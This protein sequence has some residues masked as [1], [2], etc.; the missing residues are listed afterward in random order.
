MK[1]LSKHVKDMELDEM[2]DALEERLEIIHTNTDPVALNYVTDEMNLIL[3]SAIVYHPKIVNAVSMELCADPVTHFPG[4]PIN[5]VSSERSNLIR[6]VEQ[7]LQIPFQDEFIDFELNV[8]LPYRPH[9]ATRGKVL[10]SATT[11]K[12]KTHVEQGKVP[13]Y[14]HVNIGKDDFVQDFAMRFYPH[15]VCSMKLDWIADEDFAP[16]I[17]H[18]SPNE[19]ADEDFLGAAAHYLAFRGFQ[20]PTAK[21]KDVID[22]KERDAVIEKLDAI[23]VPDHSTNLLG[24]GYNLRPGRHID[25]NAVDFSSGEPVLYKFFNFVNHRK[26]RGFKPQEHPTDIDSIRAAYAIVKHEQR[27][28][29]NIR[30]FKGDEIIE[31]LRFWQFEE[32]GY[33]E[34]I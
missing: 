9:E 3:Y 13:A 7:Y 1:A 12:A 24:D 17:V 29:G 16:T 6:F 33:F 31:K 30:T 4:I 23:W 5:S 32:Q 28:R 15:E 2:N 20:R 25:G 21:P 26:L 34:F 10:S 14:V 18:T 27:P 19:I 8:P 11:V 22:I